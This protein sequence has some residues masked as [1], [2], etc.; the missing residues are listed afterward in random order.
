MGHFPL[1]VP[2]HVTTIFGGRPSKANW[3]PGN[4]ESALKDKWWDSG[5]SPENQR[6]PLS[7]KV[8]WYLAHAPS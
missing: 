5:T 6:K 2:A 3:T 4:G 7:Y 8:L 1:Q